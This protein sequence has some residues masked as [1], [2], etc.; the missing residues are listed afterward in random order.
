MWQSQEALQMN[1]NKP[2]K[3]E[4]SSKVFFKGFYV[5]KWSNTITLT[6]WVGHRK[7]NFHIFQLLVRRKKN[8]MEIMLQN[9]TV[10]ASHIN[11]SVL[12]LLEYQYCDCTPGI[13][14]LMQKDIKFANHLSFFFLQVG[15]KRDTHKFQ[16]VEKMQRQRKI[17]IIQLRKMSISAHTSW[18]TSFII[19]FLH[20]VALNCKRIAHIMLRQSAF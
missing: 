8:W 15:G 4:D 12:S 1:F 5:M 18:S 6:R 19:K 7:S 16:R 2:L 3:K 9:I 13:V 17:M 20:C 10:K 11:Y 14:M